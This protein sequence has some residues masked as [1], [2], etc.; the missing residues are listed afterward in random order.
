MKSMK[1]RQKKINL[2]SAFLLIYL[3]LLFIFPEASSKGV[4]EGLRLCSSV[5]IPSLYPFLVC[6]SLFAKSGVLT[7][8]SHKGLSLFILSFTGGYPVGAGL[9]SELY[10]RG[11]TDKNEAVRLL[12]YCIN[13][14]V[15]FAFSTVGITLLKS[16]KAGLLILSAL[17]LSSLTTALLS[18]LLRGKAKGGSVHIDTVNTESFSSLLVSSI[19]EGLFSMIT[20]CGFVVLFSSLSFIAEAIPT[21]KNISLILR[22]V[23]EV[24]GGVV[25]TAE[26]FSLPWVTALISFGGFSTLFQLKSILRST[27]IAFLTLFAQ[28][29]ASALFSGLYTFLL[30]KLFPLPAETFGAESFTV[31]SSPSYSVSVSLCLVLMSVLFI[32]GDSVIGKKSLT[33]KNTIK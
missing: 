9:I 7:G 30:L 31:T 12:S 10:E 26:S 11:E 5:L 33:D 6:S 19:K 29:A 4:K 24:T 3:C 20:I 32:M 21:D 27:D 15:S 25:L 16:R 17:V 13:P 18:G 1:T 2:T 28:R 22:C 8:V 14:S 23:L